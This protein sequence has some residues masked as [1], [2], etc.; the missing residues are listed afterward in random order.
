M[1]FNEPFEGYLI[2]FGAAVQYKPES[3]TDTKQIRKYG[4]KTLDG[5]FIGY[6]CH[7]GGRWSKDYLILDVASMKSAECVSDF[8]INRVRT[9]LEPREYIFSLWPMARCRSLRFL[10]KRNTR[11]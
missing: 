2:P 11:I 7:H 6:H 5:L 3:D 9:I 10:N 8:K 1:R 4:G